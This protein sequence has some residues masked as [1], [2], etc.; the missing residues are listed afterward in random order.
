M[1]KHM[2]IVN[3]SPYLKKLNWAHL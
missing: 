1:A 2:K 3:A